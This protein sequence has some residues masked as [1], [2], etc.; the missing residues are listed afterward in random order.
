M[1]RL[2][3]LGN[4]VDMAGMFCRKVGVYLAF[5]K[6]DGQPLFFVVELPYICTLI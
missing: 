3:P 2:W 5:A 4:G 6:K 1:A